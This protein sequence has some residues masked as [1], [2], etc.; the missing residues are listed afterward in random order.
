[1]KKTRLIG[2]ILAHIGILLSIAF[3]VFYLVCTF[4]ADNTAEKLD[5]P[6]TASSVSA[7][8][9]HLE[10][11]IHNS[12]FSILSVGKA[13]SEKDDPHRDNLLLILDLIIPLLCLASGILLQIA[14]V[15][16]STN[17]TAASQRSQYDHISTTR[18]Q[19]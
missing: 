10:H 11:A 5:D 9:R 13:I 18:R 8:E 3:L 15:H 7:E 12:D 16:K 14:S 19:P 17:R 2:M 1:M 6:N 4:K